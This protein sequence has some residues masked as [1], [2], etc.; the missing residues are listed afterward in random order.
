MPHTIE[1]DDEVFAFLQRHA[2]PL[3]D[4]VND[5]LRRLLLSGSPAPEARTT[6]RAQARL[7]GDLLPYIAAGLV[8]AGDELVHEQPRKGLLHVAVI[9]ERGTLLVGQS[10]FQKVSPALKSCVGHEINGWGQWTH[11]PSGR[12]LQTFRDELRRMQDV[13][14]Q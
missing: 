5:V 7:S 6:T 9:T 3:V 12:T 11:R 8:G 4:S 10:E 14:G 2:E 13:D 1:V